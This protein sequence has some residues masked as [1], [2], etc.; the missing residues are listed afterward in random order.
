MAPNDDGRT[1]LAVLGSPIAHSLSPALHAAAYETLGLGWSY[2]R[3]E[4][5]SGGSTRS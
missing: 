1:R 3:H 2:G 5:A 4:V